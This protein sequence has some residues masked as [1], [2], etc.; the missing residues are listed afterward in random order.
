MLHVQT[1][2]SIVSSAP[3]CW[4]TTEYTGTLKCL[5]SQ[6]LLYVFNTDPAYTI[7]IWTRDMGETNTANSEHLEIP[8]W[9][10][11]PCPNPP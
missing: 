9:L 11:Y 10:Q 6:A 5:G 4:N 8:L 7:C 3:L 1:N 2:L